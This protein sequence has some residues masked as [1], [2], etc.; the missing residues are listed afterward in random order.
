[1]QLNWKLEIFILICTHIDDDNIILIDNI[2][3]I[4]IYIFLICSDWNC[5]FFLVMF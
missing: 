4:Y 3:Y 2:Q 1:M 5:L